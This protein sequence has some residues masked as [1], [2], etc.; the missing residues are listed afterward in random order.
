LPLRPTNINILHLD[1]YTPNSILSILMGLEE[2]P[3][4]KKART[5]GAGKRKG[6]ATGQ[7]TREI[8]VID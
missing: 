4:A 5:S 7:A 8:Y 1:Y 6:A 3:A 2:Q